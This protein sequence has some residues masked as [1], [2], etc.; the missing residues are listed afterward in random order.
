MKWRLLAALVTL[1]ALVLLVQDVPLA[2]YLRTVESNRI[3]TELQRDAFVI[4][5]R[6]SE[7]LRTNS[8]ASYQALTGMITQYS[9]P[10]D[11]IVLVTNSKGILVATSDSTRFPVGMEMT[12]RPE[13]KAALNGETSS[14]ERETLTRGVV[15]YVGV[16]VLSGPETLGAVRITYPDA[17]LT[18]LVNDRVRGLGLVAGLTMLAAIVI[19]FLLAGTI[20]RP[21]R[22]LQE[23][24]EELARG[25]LSARAVTDQGAP[26]L[27]KLGRDLN[28]MA[29][30]LDRLIA[31]QRSFAGDASHQLRT[32]LTALRL[33]LDQAAE[34]IDSRPEEAADALDDGRAEVERLQHVIDGLLRLARAEGEQQ[35]LVDVDLASIAAE[36]L[37]IWEPLAEEQGVQLELS[38]PSRA[39]ICVVPEAAEQI[40]DNYL[41]NAISISPSG[42]K[43]V[44]TIVASNYGPSP[45]TTL[46]VTDS[47]PGLSPEQRERAFD[48]FWS[49]R[50]DNAGT[51]LGLAIV[52]QLADAS[53]ARVELRE[54]ASG[55][56]E[57]VAIFQQP[58][59][60]R[61]ANSIA[62]S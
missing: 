45:T 51:G 16:P 20:T 23:T 15:L 33:R 25:D 11:S 3:I 31:A 18:S 7:A 6:S 21:I 47:G 24:T 42:S 41:D 38:T 26:E 59:P 36:R 56:V 46:L 28:Q 49:Q 17:E 2:A 62:R 37:S 22:R 60:R 9:Q 14:G 44:I 57:A 54:S 53:R 19:A 5:G 13:I 35:V 8:D 43:V 40:L 50:E 27:R 48:R 29:D 55:G 58:A 32:P 1:T 39:M 4:A 61:P 34:L 12:D 10:G 30:R 52:R